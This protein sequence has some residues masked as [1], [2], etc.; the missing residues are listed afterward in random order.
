MVPGLSDVQALLPRIPLGPHWTVKDR[1]TVDRDWARYYQRDQLLNVTGNKELL[2]LYKCSLRLM[3]CLPEDIIS[4][5]FDLAY[6][7][8]QKRALTRGQRP[9]WGAPFCRS[10]TALMVHPMWNGSTAP[11][12]AAIQYAVIVDTNDNGP[13]DM[14]VRGHDSFLTELLKR[15]RLQPDRNAVEL[16][17]QLHKE[18]SA[19]E[20]DKFGRNTGVDP[21]RWDALF[22][23]IEK[24]AKSER[25]GKPPAPQAV[26]GTSEP[27]LVHHRH[28]ELIEKGLDSMVHMGF[29]YFLPLDVYGRGIHGR[30]SAK[31]YPLAKDLPALREYSIICERERLAYKAKLAKAARGTLGNPPADG[32]QANS[33]VVNQTSK[34][35]EVPNTQHRDELRVPHIQEDEGAGTPLQDEGIPET[36]Y[37]LRG[38]KRQRPSETN[39]TSSDNPQKRARSENPLS[40]Q[41]RAQNQLLLRTLSE[42]P[43]GCVDIFDM[44][45]APTVSRRVNESPI[46]SAQ[47]EGQDMELGKGDDAPQ[48]SQLDDENNDASVR[49]NA[50]D[51]NVASQIQ[52][53]DDDEI[54]S[55]EADY[56]P[57]WYLSHSTHDAD[58]NFFGY[59][60]RPAFRLPP[61]R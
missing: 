17:R 8:D 22:R 20:L 16:R 18:L 26:R 7:V 27:F 60:E 50:G 10:L 41:K 4:C 13:W 25:L 5:R 56:N 54:T 15:K 39:P 46:G 40:P 57:R 1:D 33:E 24:M 14:E 30:R 11:L 52:H 43:G 45:T 6:D 48:Q 42:S 9:V 51:E 53:D 44:D 37:T 34:E 61:L 28:L 29:P 49:G 21:S 36:Q 58:D 47:T 31:D 55:P 32:T 59:Q 3:R 23:A 38:Q 2:T 19:S 12:A 35:P